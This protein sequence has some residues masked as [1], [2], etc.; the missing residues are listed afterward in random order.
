MP[1]TFQVPM[2]YFFLQFFTFTTRQYY[3]WVSFPLWLSYFFPSGAI[4]NCPPLFPSS[5]LVTV[6]PEGSSSGVTSFGLSYCP[7]VLTGRI[8]EG[9]FSPPLDHVLLELFTITCL[10]WIALL[11]MPHSFTE[12]PK[13]LCHEKAMIHE[14]AT[15]VLTNQPYSFMD[16][17]LPLWLVYFQEQETHWWLIKGI[18][19]LFYYIKENKY[20]VYLWTVPYQ[21]QC[22]SFTKECWVVMSQP[23]KWIIPRVLVFIYRKNHYLSEIWTLTRVCLVL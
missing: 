7:R 15:N 21:R 11:H 10:S 16:C 14:E 18:Y 2:Q 12:W 1:Q 23:G 13:P 20:R 5:I 19:L 4:S 6:W 17:Q 3:N 9:V 22:T 8:P